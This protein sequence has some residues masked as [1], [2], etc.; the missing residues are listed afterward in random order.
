MR[1][2]AFLLELESHPWPFCSTTLLDCGVHV[3]ELLREPPSDAAP[4][5]GCTFVL[6]HEGGRLVVCG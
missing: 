6:V 3:E 2:L 4:V 5:E 1:L